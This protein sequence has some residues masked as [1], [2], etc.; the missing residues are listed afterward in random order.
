MTI[1]DQRQDE[2]ANEWI[3][4]G[5]FG[6][7]Y[8]CPRFGKIYTTINILEK[9][10]EMKKIL[11]AY[12]DVKI[13][14]SWKADFKKRGY[15]DSNVTYTTYVSL[16]KYV[17][18][19]YNLIVLDEP[20]L[21]SPAQILQVVELKR[22]NMFILGL[23]GTLTAGTKKWL[24][25]NLHLPVTVTY[26]MAQGIEE[27]I[28]A[29]YEITVVKTPLDNTTLREYGKKNKTEKQQFN[30]L[31][32][33]INSAQ[34]KGNDAG[35][36]R[37]NRMRIIQKSIAKRNATRKIIRE[38][39]AERILVFCGLTDIAD[40]LLIPSYHSKSSEKKIFE[41]FVTG[42]GNHLAVV[43]IGNTGITYKPLNFVIINYFDS[44]AEN[45]AQKINR[46]MSMEYDNPD[47][48][49]H[50]YIVSTDEPIELA[51]LN[52]ALEFFDKTKIK[53]L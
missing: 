32:F 45:M 8:L 10:P 24:M 42:K 34:A 39:M 12:P 37:I 49:A 52:R 22:R 43:K 19:S 11:I 3:R 15:D 27:G 20:Q 50:I 6:I 38:N 7:L 48:K 14:D 18:E 4:K 1:R 35:F 44:N 21:M 41:D 13:K 2:F 17:K 29:D 51:W 40:D 33:L 30:T 26:T 36:F 16:K 23:T 25:N 9:R 31:T 46:C 47:K 53:Y 5:M 28:V